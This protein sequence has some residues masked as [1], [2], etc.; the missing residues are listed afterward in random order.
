MYQIDTNPFLRLHHIF[1]RAET[2]SK[3]ITTGD[4][5]KA[6]QRRDCD[7]ALSVRI[8]CPLRTTSEWVAVDFT[9]AWRRPRVLRC[10][11]LKRPDFFLKCWAGFDSNMANVPRM[12]FQRLHFFGRICCVAEIRTKTKNLV[13]I[14]LL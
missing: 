5:G 2:F 11:P 13:F 4:R 12:V 8:G 6:Q 10:Q 7:N 14:M 9:L 1:E 3:T